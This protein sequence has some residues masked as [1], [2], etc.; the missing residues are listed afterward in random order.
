MCLRDGGWLPSSFVLYFGFR[1]HVLPGVMAVLYP[2]VDFNHRADSACSPPYPC[3]AC[4]FL[5]SF[6]VL[7]PWGHLRDS[8]VD[9]APRWAFPFAKTKELKIPFF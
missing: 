2:T 6:P 9:L 7:G 4:S 8:A 3:L 1:L 5:L